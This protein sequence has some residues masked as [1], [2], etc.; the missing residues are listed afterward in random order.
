[1][2]VIKDWAAVMCCTA[3]FI[4][5]VEIIA[6]SGSY[7]KIV[8]LVLAGIT[9][10]VIMSP[11]LDIRD[12][13]LDFELN[14]DNRISD[15]ERIENS[16]KKQTEEMLK[17][18]VKSRIAAIASEENI[19]EYKIEVVTN[20]DNSNCISIEQVKVKFD[21][22]S[23]EKENSFIDEVYKQTGI[24]VDVERTGE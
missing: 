4:A 23:V 20:I 1:M 22:I 5:V 8:K 2:E 24:V 19:V 17:D 14:L 11:L 10:V 16:I 15:S 13:K 6:P 9:V 3:V 12:I 21:G 18:L 7:K